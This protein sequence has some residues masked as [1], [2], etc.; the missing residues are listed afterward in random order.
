MI[1]IINIFF[2]IDDVKLIIYNITYILLRHMPA[3]RGFTTT[4]YCVISMQ[5][6]YTNLTNRFNKP[7]N[8]DLTG[9]T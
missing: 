8:S 9:V 1:I 2:W 5:C 7:E 6:Q 4:T 3:H